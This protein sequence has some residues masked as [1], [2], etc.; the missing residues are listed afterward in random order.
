MF[1]LR[2]PQKKKFVSTHLFWPNGNQNSWM[3]SIVTHFYSWLPRRLIGKTALLAVFT[4]DQQNGIDRLL[5]YALNA[6]RSARQ[7]LAGNSPNFNR[8]GS[9][10]QIAVPARHCDHKLLLLLVYN[11]VDLLGSLPSANEPPR[12]AKRR[13]SSAEFVFEWKGQSGFVYA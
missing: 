5:F 3:L 6:L 7:Q 9:I 11:P 4:N 12:I 8:L 2:Y 10:I 1:R 13:Y